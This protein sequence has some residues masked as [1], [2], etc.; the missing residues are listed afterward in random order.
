M[1]VVASPV[2]E[3]DPDMRYQ[4]ID[5]V[6]ARALQ[7]DVARDH[8]LFGWAVMEDPP[9]HP[10]AFVARL[11]ADAPTSYAFAGPD[12]G[13]DPRQPAARPGR[14]AASKGAP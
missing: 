3:A 8:P 14:T 12:A 7:E 4:I 10:G 9:E 2:P 1:E 13:R 11:V 5:A 6:M